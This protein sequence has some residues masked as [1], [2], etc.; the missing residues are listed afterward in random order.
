[1]ARLAFVVFTA[2]ALCAAANPWANVQ[3]LPGRS[4]LRI[5]KKGS[6]APVVATLADANEERIVVALDAKKQ[7]LT[8]FRDEI[9]RIDARPVNAPGSKKTV[10]TTEKATDPDYTPKA[11]PGPALPGASSSTNVSFGG[12][13][14]FKTVYLRPPGSH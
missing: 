2:L 6:S 5:Y 14:D 3:A 13:P 8:I 1:M 10:T 9:D 11:T 7:Q 12:K 4:E